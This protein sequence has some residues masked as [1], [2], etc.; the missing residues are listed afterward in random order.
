M[1][2]ALRDCVL[3]LKQTRHDPP[4]VM[5][6]VFNQEITKQFDEVHVNTTCVRDKACC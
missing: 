3:P 2:G 6:D 1:F 5:L 4:E